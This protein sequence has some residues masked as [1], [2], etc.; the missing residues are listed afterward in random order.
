[1]RNHTCYTAVGIALL[2]GTSL[3]HAQTVITREITDQPVETVITQQ[4]GAMV[5]AQ[6][7]VM[8]PAPGVVVRRR[9]PTLPVETV[10]TVRTTRS[11]HPVHHRIA[12]RPFVRRAAPTT[13]KR[14]VVRERVV[15]APAVAAITEPAYT[16]VVR[17]PVVSA[18]TYPP[19]LYDVVPGPVPAVVAP[20]VIGAAVVAPVPAYRYVYEPGRILVIDANT[21]IAVQAIPR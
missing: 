21:G 12:S 10:E 16:E 5:I 13:T 17:P 14:T 6:E 8:V 1:M 11:Y 20:P 19:P 2:A 3:A 15:P 4:P 9:A 7:P 18:V